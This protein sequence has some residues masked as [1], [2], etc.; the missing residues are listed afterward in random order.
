MRSQWW[1]P[2]ERLLHEKAP[3]MPILETLPSE[4]VTVADPS[5]QENAGAQENCLT[6]P[7]TQYR[8]VGR[9]DF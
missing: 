3:R 4:P 2:T 5:G 6:S 9:N 8:S 7:E 1:P